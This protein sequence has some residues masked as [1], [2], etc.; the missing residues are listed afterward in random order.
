M[1]HKRIAA[2]AAGTVAKRRATDRTQASRPKQT[3]AN[4][5]HD[6]VPWLRALGFSAAEARRAAERC[7]HMPDAPI[8]ERVRIA[9]RSFRARGTHVER[10]ATLAP[11]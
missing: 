3:L 2:A 7:E 1:R 5:G 6:V 10:P 11:A 8:E 9:L 4:D